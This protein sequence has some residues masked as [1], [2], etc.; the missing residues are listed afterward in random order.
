MIIAYTLL[1][2]IKKVQNNEDYLKIIHYKLLLYGFR[3][4]KLY[5]DDGIIKTITILLLI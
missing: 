2:R 4:N 1:S 3:F 5:D